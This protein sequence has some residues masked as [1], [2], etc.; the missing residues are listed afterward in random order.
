SVELVEFIVTKVAEKSYTEPIKSAAEG[1][2]P[3][4]EIPEP[5]GLLIG[6][7]YHTKSEADGS[8]TF[9]GFQAVFETKLGPRLGAWHGM[10]PEPNQQAGELRAP[11]GFAISGI[12]IYSGAGIQNF[13]VAYS[14][15]AE[16]GLTTRR[17]LRSKVTGN[18]RLGQVRHVITPGGQPIVGISGTIDKSIRS[19]GLISTK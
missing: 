17:T 14:H 9:C 2:A 4:Q 18:Y 5:G 8:R 11:R 6:L 19:L 1:A 13:Q 10:A 3:F 16:T 7:N 12:S 15:I